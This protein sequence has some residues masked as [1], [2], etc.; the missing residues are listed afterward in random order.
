MGKEN[1]I[2]K[3]DLRN[4]EAI[5][6]A[7]VRHLHYILFII[8]IYI[9]TLYIQGLENPHCLAVSDDDV[10]YVGESGPNRILKIE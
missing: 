5:S 3:V 8:Y 4:G 2:F 7:P 6:E 1:E 10:I 9:I